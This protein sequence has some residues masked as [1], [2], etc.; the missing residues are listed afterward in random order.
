[1]SWFLLILMIVVYTLQ[2]FLMRLYSDHYPGKPEMVAPVFTIVSGIAVVVVSFAVSGFSFVADWQTLLFGAAGGIAMVVYN[3]SIVKSVQNGPYSVM[4]VFQIS[5]AIIIPIFSASLIFGD[6]IST[7]QLICIAVVL[8]SQL[9][10][11]F[12]K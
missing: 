9:L 5:G 6:S 3:D 4:M 1:M 10:I 2:S 7:V 8:V 11:I 12:I